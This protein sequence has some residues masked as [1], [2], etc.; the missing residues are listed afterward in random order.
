MT[1]W[2][3]TLLLIGSLTGGSYYLQYQTALKN[4]VIYLDGGGTQNVWVDN[5]SHYY[6]PVF[7]QVNHRHRVH[8]IAR[9]CADGDSCT[10]FVV[11]HVILRTGDAL[12]GAAPAVVRDTA[13]DPEVLAEQP[14]SQP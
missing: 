11:R 6:C 4:A 2:I 9:P 7:C 12:P 1:T 3:T 10:H 5:H 14:A 8:D 13:A